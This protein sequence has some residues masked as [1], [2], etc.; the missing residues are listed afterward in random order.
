VGHLEITVGRTQAVDALVRTTVVVVPDPQSQ[1]LTR[2]VET[3][4]LRPVQKLTKH[5][6]PETLDFAQ[7]HRMVRCR[8]DMLDPVLL[9][10]LLKL[11]RPAPVRVLPA[12][13]GKHLLGYTVFADA[14][15][16]H[17]KHIGRRLTPK[18]F[19]TGDIP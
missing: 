6:L 18:D 4:E 5:R 2:F 14:P 3:A 1:T 8:L 7:R 9:Q 16:V 11:R 10:F 12:V 15:T 17:L 13:V 19:Q